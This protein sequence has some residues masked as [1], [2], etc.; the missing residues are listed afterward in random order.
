MQYTK[1]SKLN[2][3]SKCNKLLII[4]TSSTNLQPKERSIPA[5]HHNVV[6]LPKRQSVYV[7]LFIFRAKLLFIQLTYLRQRDTIDGLTANG[8]LGLLLN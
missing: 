8:L 2:T 3:T 4:I 7:P 5:N 6:Q 1:A